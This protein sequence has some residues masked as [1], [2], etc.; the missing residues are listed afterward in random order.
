M[1]IHLTRLPGASVVFDYYDIKIT[2]V[3]AAITAQTAANQCVAGP[4]LNP[5]A[6][7]TVF[8]DGATFRVVD[9]IQ[10]SINYAALLARGIDFS[11]AYSFELE[12]LVGKD[13]GEVSWRLRGN[14]LIRQQDF[15]NI[16]NPSFATNNDSNLGLPRVR[17]L[18]TL[19]YAPTDS[20]RFIWDWD[21]QASQELFDEDLLVNDPDNRLEEFLNTGDYNQHDFTMRWDVGENVELRGGVVNAFDADPP[22]WVAGGGIPAAF[23]ANVDTFDLFGR[24]FFVG[25]RFR[26]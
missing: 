23:A 17:F 24:R 3:I 22:P 10:G 20:L 11:A 19:S 13:W 1:C 21:W 15:V 6:C 18:S 7:N 26:N 8:R 12:D 5:N 4:S 2:N 9:F 14:Y 25:A 16:A